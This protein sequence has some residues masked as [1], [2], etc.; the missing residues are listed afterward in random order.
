MVEFVVGVGPVDDTAGVVFK[1]SSIESAG[2]GA[3]LVDFVHDGSSASDGSV[4]GDVVDEVSGGRI[5]FTV[6]VAGTAL[7]ELRAFK[8]VG[9]ASSLVV[10]AG[11]VG[12]GVVVDVLVSNHRITTIAALIGGLAGDEDLRS[13]VD[14]GPGSVTQDLDTIGEGRGGREGPA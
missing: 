14:I 2:D 6:G 9:P 4:F 7:D 10:G 5:A 1:G 13:E 3:S 12:D 11:F 8:T